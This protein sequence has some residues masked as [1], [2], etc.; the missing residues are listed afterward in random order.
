MKRRASFAVVSKMQAHCLAVLL[1]IPRKA[2]Q[3]IRAMLY[4]T[5]IHA[6]RQGRTTH[7]LA[8]RNVHK[9][10]LSA[11]ALLDLDVTWLY[12]EHPDSYL[13]CPLTP[14]ALER[15]IVQMQ[16]PP[17]AV[18]ITSPDYLGNCADLHALAAV[19]HR[20]GVLL[21]V[22]NAH[23]AYLHFLCTSRHP[24][25]CGA[26]LCCDSAHKTLPCLTGGAYLH[27]AVPTLVPQAKRALA[28][29]GSTSPSYLILQSLDAVNAYLAADY[30]Q[31]L[32]AYAHKV[33]QL[34]QELERHGY[35]LRGA[36]PLKICICAKPYG[37]T[38]IEL[39]QCLAQKNIVCEFADLD[40]L[41]VMLT[42]EV[43]QKGLRRLSVAL[44]LV[45]RRPVI[46]QGYPQLRRCEQVMSIRRAALAPSQVLPIEQCIG[47]VCAA[48]SV[49]CPPAVPIVVC[50]ER[51]NKAAVDCFSYYGIRSCAIVEE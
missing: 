20:H 40:F 6:K 43:T 45:P 46:A 44:R 34:K 35:V 25:D 12:S 14:D 17:T 37:Y 39:A 13:D 19:C 21:L 23:G 50:G 51:I 16:Q 36:E 5:Q 22:D 29:F 38:G 24:M 48:P 33:L 9:T 26:D 49:G 18:Y 3:C 4:L 32:E 10:F 30:R 47:R 11:A 7:I 41:V 15:A 42:P 27:I 8:A 28:L 1:F 2:L 31:K